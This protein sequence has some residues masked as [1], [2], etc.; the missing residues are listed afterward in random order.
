MSEHSEHVILSDNNIW[1][2]WGSLKVPKSAKRAF[3]ADFCYCYRH[4]KNTDYCV[5]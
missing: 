5:W 1:L 2:A 3:A 4:G